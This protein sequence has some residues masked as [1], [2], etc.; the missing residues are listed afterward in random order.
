[1]YIY[2]YMNMYVYIYEWWMIKFSS[3]A[4]KKFFFSPGSG[5]QARKRR[6]WGRGKLVKW[7]LLWAGHDERAQ[8]SSPP[9]GRLHTVLSSREKVS[10][11]HPPKPHTHKILYMHICDRIHTVISFLFFFL[12]LTFFFLFLFFVIK[13]IMHVD[14]Q[15]QQSDRQTDRQTRQ[16]DRYRIRRQIDW[17]K[18]EDSSVWFFIVWLAWN[19]IGNAKRNT[20]VWCF[21]FLLTLVCVFGVLSQSRNA[22][23]RIVR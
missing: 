6:V 11:T 12:F 23:R 18:E 19:K 1:M 10:N 21:L 4:V 17:L 22:C 7:A 14:A 15:L 8:C 9:G 3:G 20:V 2:I 16:T 5:F 13:V